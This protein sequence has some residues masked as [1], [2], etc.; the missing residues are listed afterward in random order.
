MEP[1]E[2][3]LFISLLKNKVKQKL[4]KIITTKEAVLFVIK[5]LTK[6]IY[7]LPSMTNET[8]LS[9][10]VSLLCINFS[11]SIPN[12][13]KSWSYMSNSV[14]VPKIRKKCSYFLLWGHSTRLWDN[15]GQSIWYDLKGTFMLCRYTLHSKKSVQKCR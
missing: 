12:I 15:F 10:V 6:T 13:P 1:G 4:S 3:N 14:Q 5:K 2:T 8:Y 9:Y 11:E 7:S